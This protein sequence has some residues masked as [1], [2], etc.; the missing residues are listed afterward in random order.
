M[1]KRLRLIALSG[2]LTTITVA[3]VLIRSLFVERPADL[4]EFQ[5]AMQLIQPLHEK[6]KPPERGD[7]LA[8]YGEAGQTFQDFVDFGHNVPTPERQT[9]YVLP[10]GE[11]T[12]AQDRLIDKTTELL[13]L[14]YGVP[15]KRLPNAPLGEIPPDAHRGSAENDD[16]QLLGPYLI[17]DVIAPRIPRDAFAAIGLTTFDL[18]PGEGFNFVFGLAEGG[19]AVWSLHRYGNL[20][21]DEREQALFRERVFKVALHETGHMLAIPHC[22]AYECRMNGANGIDELDR[23]PMWFCPECEAKIWWACR[24]NRNN[25]YQKLVDFAKQQGLSEA[26]E[27][28]QRSAT[29]LTA[30]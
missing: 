20:D 4:T 18:W 6:K 15:A 23:Q 30:R 25:R 10:V 3:A 29:V 24:G 12:P 8:K 22:T 7:W 21:G 19:R 5:Q 28:W 11:F 2:F 27:F 26:A 14:F 16:E 1:R 13:G 17:N 9:I